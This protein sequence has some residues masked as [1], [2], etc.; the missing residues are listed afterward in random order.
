MSRQ[1]DSKR[2]SLCVTCCIP[3]PLILVERD[4]DGAA[5]WTC[6]FCGEHYWAVLDPTA[7]EDQ[8]HNVQ[9]FIPEER[10]E[11]EGHGL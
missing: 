11:S 4:H 7:P 9:R 8:R 1:F 2:I 3:V 5:A 10:D 6:T